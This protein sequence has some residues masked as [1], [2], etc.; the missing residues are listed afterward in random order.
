MYVLL[1]LYTKDH[2]SLS[3]AGAMVKCT[4]GCGEQMLRKEVRV[5]AF[6]VAFTLACVRFDALAK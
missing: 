6:T 3:C 2:L 4:A 1:I 5:V